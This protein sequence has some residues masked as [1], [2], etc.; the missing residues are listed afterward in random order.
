YT[1]PWS[2]ALTPIGADPDPI[3]RPT[4]IS[5]E[6]E[7]VEIQV[8]KGR[9]EMHVALGRATCTVTK[10]DSLDTCSLADYRFG[11]VRYGR[12]SASRDK[13]VDVAFDTRHTEMWCE[14]D[15]GRAAIM[16]KASDA[17]ANLQLSDN[18]ALV[19]DDEVML[20]TWDHS[21]ELPHGDYE[22]FYSLR[23][24]ISCIPEADDCWR[25]GGIEVTNERREVAAFTLDAIEFFALPDDPLL[26]EFNRS[27]A[28]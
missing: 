22:V 9:Y 12:V 20:K 21:V 19:Q 2:V 26:P 7:N 23:T 24:D 4:R 14:S 17:P 15:C 18:F 10:Q 3:F 8:I 16:V 25:L 13:T 5:A 27:S 1:P 28:S 11:V 6:A